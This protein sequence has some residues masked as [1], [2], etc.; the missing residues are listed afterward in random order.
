MSLSTSNPANSQQSRLQVEAALSNMAREFR[1]F[2]SDVDDLMKATNNLTGEELNKAK[3]KLEQRISTA[4][5]SVEELGG[6][7]ADRARKTA[8][9][10]DNYV[11]EQPWTAIGAGAG[12]G[13]VVG[14]L[15]T[16][17]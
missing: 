16:R 3:V 15:L 4:R 8:V 12:I 7:I 1:N 6:T 14:Y 9:S 17:R 10:A 13:L 11:H 2:V 5:R